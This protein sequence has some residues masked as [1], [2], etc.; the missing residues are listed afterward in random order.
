MPAMIDDML[1][2]ERLKMGFWDHFLALMI[3]MVTATAF[4]ANLLSKGSKVEV[5]IRIE[6]QGR[7][8]CSFWAFYSTNCKKL[9]LSEWIPI[10]K[11][12]LFHLV[13]KGL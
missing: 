7:E 4:S 9:A 3:L 11:I 13:K 1:K 5:A 6:E 2:N 10:I 8:P 12:G